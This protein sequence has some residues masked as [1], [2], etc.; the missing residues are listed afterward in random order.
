MG[1]S[2]FGVHRCFGDGWEAVVGDCRLTIAGGAAC[3]SRCRNV[4][5]VCCVW[6]WVCSFRRRGVHVNK[7]WWR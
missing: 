4:V 1:E 6:L 5:P 7:R 3:S 2:D